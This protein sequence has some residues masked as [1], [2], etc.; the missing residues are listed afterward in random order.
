MV[1]L[2]YSRMS[3]GFDLLKKGINMRKKDK[4]FIAWS[5]LILMV[6]SVVAGL[7]AYLAS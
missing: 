7:L 2:M 4:Q 3:V 1:L 6:G 5:L